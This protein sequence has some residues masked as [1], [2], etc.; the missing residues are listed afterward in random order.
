M[1]KSYAWIVSAY[2]IALSLCLFNVLSIIYPS[3]IFIVGGYS[4]D[5]GCAL[6]YALEMLS[7]DL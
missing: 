1:T 7:I 6:F 4:G 5:A 3:S 2:Q